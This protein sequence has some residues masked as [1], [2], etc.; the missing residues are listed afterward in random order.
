MKLK[1]LIGKR[2]VDILIKLESEPYGLDKADCFIVLD[3]GKTI[4]IPFGVNDDEA[5]TRELHKNAVSVFNQPKWWQAYNKP[6]LELKDTIIV[7]II[8]Y[9][10]N[11]PDKSLLLLDNK[12]LITEV[13]VAPQGTGHAGLWWYNSLADV[14][15]KYGNKY[16]RFSELKG[17]V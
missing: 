14:E 4:G 6:V 9:P 13:L 5:W 11:W 17:S 8:S 15:N 10:D 3:N 7:D 2:I 12:K 1:D 16:D